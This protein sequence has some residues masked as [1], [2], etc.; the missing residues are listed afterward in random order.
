MQLGVPT[1]RELQRKESCR[2]ACLI[3]MVAER[4][5]PTGGMAS[6]E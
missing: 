5:I 2:Y 3:E 4:L 1:E 6:G